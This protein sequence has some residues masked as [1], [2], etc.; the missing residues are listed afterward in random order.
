MNNRYILIVLLLIIL[1]SCALD[2]IDKKTGMS[3]S[4]ISIDES[5]HNGVFLY[6]LKPDKYQFHDTG[7]SFNIK[8]VWVEDA[9]GYECENYDAVIKKLGYKQVVVN[10]DYK[11][12][13]SIYNYSLMVEDFTHCAYI[14]SQ[15]SF[16]YNEEDTF[17]LLFTWMEDFTNYRIID[18]VYF[19]RAN[20]AP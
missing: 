12:T 1:Q 14:G 19:V 13:D 11:K 15:L 9:W 10:V 20:V 16:I 17:I 4:S 18:T 7:I 6:E 8:N 5:K 3:K 2:C